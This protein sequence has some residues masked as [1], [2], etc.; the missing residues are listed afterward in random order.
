[1]CY[2]LWVVF[3]KKKNVLFFIFLVVVVVFADAYLNQ[4]K[5]SSDSNLSHSVYI[6]DLTVH[7]VLL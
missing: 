3:K 6:C 4:F 2:L 5:P 1:M 7:A